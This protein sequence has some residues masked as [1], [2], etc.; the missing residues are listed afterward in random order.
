MSQ[1]SFQQPNFRLS[2]AARTGWWVLVAFILFVSGNPVPAFANAAT[3]PAPETAR[4]ITCRSE[5]EAL[6]LGHTFAA[7]V[8]GRLIATSGTA[9]MQPLIRGKAYL[10]VRDLPYDSIA[11][12]AL[13]VY[14]GR[15]NAAKKDRLTMMHRTVQRDAGGW[16]MSG[17]NNARTES[18]DRVTS[19]NYL[20]TVTMILEFP[21]A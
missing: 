9:S 13:L 6:T 14:S 20:G 12:G 3:S 10:V 8:Q 4:K 7:S 21:Q 16:L 1:R 18:W 2:L 5:Q 11:Q 15:P 19:S 17:D